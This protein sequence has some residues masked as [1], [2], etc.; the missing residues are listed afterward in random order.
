MSKNIEIKVEKM[1]EVLERDGRFGQTKKL[2]QHGDISVYEHCIRVAICSLKMARTLKW[3]VNEEDLLRGALL[4]DYFLYDWHVQ[5]GTHRL[6]G[7]F[8]PKTAFY[9]AQKDFDLSPIEADVILHHMFP[10]TVLPP[11]HKEAWIVCLA[12]KICATGETLQ[13]L[14]RKR[15]FS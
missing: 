15:Y 1:A 6:H 2:M 8:H 3:K 14:R 11:L 9:K 10:L 7:F 5:D 4:H 13:P 12:D